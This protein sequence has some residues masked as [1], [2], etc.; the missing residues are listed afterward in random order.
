MNSFAHETKRTVLTF[1]Q[2]VREG[3]HDGLFTVSTVINDI[4]VHH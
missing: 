2:I 1:D 4:I 3:V